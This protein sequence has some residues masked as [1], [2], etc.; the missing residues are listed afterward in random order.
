[1]HRTAIV[2]PCYNEA[3]R[4][5]LDQLYEAA[6]AS[7]LLS[8]VMVDDGSQDDT[9]PLLKNL[10][11]ESPQQFQVLALPR[12]VGKAEA[13]RQ[14]LLTAF[15]RSPTLAGYFDADLATPLSEVAPMVDL[16]EGPEV[17]MVMG[18]RVKLLG[19]S[20]QRSP[21]RHYLGRVFASVASV[22][23][24]LDVYDTQCGAKL[25][26]VSQAMRRVFEMPFRANWSFDVEVIARMQALARRGELPPAERAIVEYPLRSWHDIS[27]SKLGPR[28]ALRAGMDLARIWRHYRPT[29]KR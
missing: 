10:Q 2:V 28:G 5:R 17:Q 15:A 16:F 26:R 23:L 13:V 7:S 21:L 4:L 8:F 18:S 19:R 24:G 9:L 20:V 29:A 6:Q 27:G 11:A 22:T 1:M 14:G 12:N 25:F 3:E